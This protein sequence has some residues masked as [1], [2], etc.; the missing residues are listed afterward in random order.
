M[1]DFWYWDRSRII[2]LIIACS[3][4]ILAL[5]IDPSFYLLCVLGFVILSLACIWFSDELG[6]YTG[7]VR[8]IPVRQT[9]GCFIRFL[10]WVLLLLPVIIFII[11]ALSNE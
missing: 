11:Y 8:F 9:P 6:G 10:G 3:Y 2:S 5:L 1:S 7:F 4:I